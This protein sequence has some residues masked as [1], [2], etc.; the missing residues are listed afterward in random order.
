MV[1]SPYT[2]IQSLCFLCDKHF[3]MHSGFD[4]DDPSLHPSYIAVHNSLVPLTE[5]QQR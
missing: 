3:G 4:A 2:H 5:L 1:P